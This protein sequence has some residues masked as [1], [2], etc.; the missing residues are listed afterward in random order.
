MRGRPVKSQ[1]RQNVVE[2][3]YYLNKGYGY[4]ISKIYNEVFPKVTQRSIYYHLRKGVQTKEIEVHTVE[5]EKGDFSWGN[6]VEKTYYA[7]GRNAEPQ[8]NQK[9]QEFLEKWS[10]PQANSGRKFMRLV[11]KFRKEK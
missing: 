6:S 2:I 10:R 7:L 1:I 3:L 5:L 11:N 8:S 4:Q 9:I